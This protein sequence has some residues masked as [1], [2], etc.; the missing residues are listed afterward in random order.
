M[1]YICYDSHAQVW[2]TCYNAYAEPISFSSPVGP[3][4]SLLGDDRLFVS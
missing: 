3:Q 4:L 1:V 2:Y